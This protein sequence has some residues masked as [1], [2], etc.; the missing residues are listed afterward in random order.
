VG[1]P[2]PLAVTKSAVLPAANQARSSAR[3][4][5]IGGWSVRVT[6]VCG[7]APSWQKRQSSVQVLGRVR[8]TPSE[9]P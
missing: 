5:S 7:V 3:I 4:S 6:V 1:S 8:S 9:R 2:E